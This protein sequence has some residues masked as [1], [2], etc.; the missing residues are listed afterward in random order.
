MK[1]PGRVFVIALLLFGSF[2][3][4][5]QTSYTLSGKVIAEDYSPFQSASVFIAQ[6]STGSFSDSL[7]EFTVKLP[8]GWNEV[9]FSYVGYKVVKLKLFMQRDTIVEIPMKY[10]LTLGEVTIVDKKKLKAADHDETG[11]ITMRKENFLS[12]PAMLGENDPMRAVQMQPGVQSG[13]EGAR[14]IFVRG[15]SPDQNLMLLDGATVYNPSHLY[16]FVSVFNSDAVE[17]IAIYKDR[18][19]AA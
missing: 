3:L 9:S 13:N 11:V 16:G 14:G 5:C 2:P 10:D 12:L 1:A 19:P 7:G 18:Y 8:A 17:Q 4:F 15:G 6:F